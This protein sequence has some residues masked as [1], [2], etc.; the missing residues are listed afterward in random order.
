MADLKKYFHT[1]T[2]LAQPAQSEKDFLLQMTKLYEIHDSSGES[3]DTFITIFEFITKNTLWF[4]SKDRKRWRKFSR[5]II[6]KVKEY[7]TH[8]IYAKLIDIL[9]I[10]FCKYCLLFTE[11]NQR[12]CKRDRENHLV[13]FQK[14][15]YE[16]VEHIMEFKG[17]K[18][19]KRYTC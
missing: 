8:K 13:L 9:P 2:L 15:P 18:L 5:V 16:L 12:L 6:D 7:Y 17:V 11:N 14:L 3:Q 10:R 4:F 19:R 1:N